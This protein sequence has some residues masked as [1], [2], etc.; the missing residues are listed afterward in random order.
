MRRQTKR[1]SLKLP[2]VSTEKSSLDKSRNIEVE[3]PLKPL[4]ESKSQLRRITPDEEVPI[5]AKPKLSY[6]TVGQVRGIEEREPRA[7]DSSWT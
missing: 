7:P 5:D 6:M 4:Q 2:V 1:L 3:L